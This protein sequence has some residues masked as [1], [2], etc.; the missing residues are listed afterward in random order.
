MLSEISQRKTNTV[1]LSLVHRTKL[2][3]RSE[4]VSEGWEKWGN[5]GQDYKLVVIS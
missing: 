5:V 2:R 4:L 3:N 1:I